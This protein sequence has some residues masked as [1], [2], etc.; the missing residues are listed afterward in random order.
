MTRIKVCGV[1]SLDD[2]AMC[3][4]AGVDAIG[5]NFWARSVRRIEM[6]AAEAIARTFGARVRIVLVFVDAHET[7]IAA[8]RSALGDHVH[9]QLHGGESPELLARLTPHAYKAIRAGDDPAPFG[10][11]EILLDASGDTPG[12]TGKTFDWDLAVPIARERKLWL[13]G[14][15][16]PENVADAIRRVRPFGVDVASGVERE[17]GRKD[18]ELVTEF[19]RAVRDAGGA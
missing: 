2:A 8:V 17:P 11:D 12:G 16:R 9:V 18:L 6:E 13:A 1:R 4:A 7:E 14:G 10:G 15:L 3:I 5:L 19:V